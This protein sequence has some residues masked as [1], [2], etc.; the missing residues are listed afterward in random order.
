MSFPAISYFERANSEWTENDDEFVALLL[1]GGSLTL[2]EGEGPDCVI[3]KGGG[4]G[5]VTFKRVCPSKNPKDET[6]PKLFKHT[7]G[8]FIIHNL[9]KLSDPLPP[10]SAKFNNCFSANLNHFVCADVIYGI[11]LSQNLLRERWAMANK[12]PHSKTRAIRMVL[13]PTAGCTWIHL[14]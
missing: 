6:K 10:L 8:A 13:E 2:R 11:P 9:L 14:C 7:V 4:M 1:P 5:G 12:A 3:V